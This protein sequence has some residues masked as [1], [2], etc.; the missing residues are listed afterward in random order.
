[1]EEDTQ[2]CMG[3]PE[4]TDVWFVKMITGQIPECKVLKIVLAVFPKWFDL[5]QNFIDAG[6]A[7][8]TF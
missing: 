4:L 6:P 8:A 1:M 2:M 5:S 3:S 7:P